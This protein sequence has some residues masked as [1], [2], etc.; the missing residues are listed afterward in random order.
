MTQNDTTP[1]VAQAAGEPDF[2][3]LYDDLFRRAVEETNGAPLSPFIVRE[4]YRLGQSS[5]PAAD[6]SARDI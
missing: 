2:E 4:A 3:K 5:R 1:P 6:Q